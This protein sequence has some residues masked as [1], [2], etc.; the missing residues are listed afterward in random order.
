MNKAN[1]I[2]LFSFYATQ[3]LIW[4]RLN[5]NMAVKQHMKISVTTLSYTGYNGKGQLC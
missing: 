5:T 1:N 3:Y 2:H 4:Q